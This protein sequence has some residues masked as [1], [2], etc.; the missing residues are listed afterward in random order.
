MM[1][2]T[3]KFEYGS[4]NYEQM[5]V[6]I[7]K[8]KITLTKGKFRLDFPPSFVSDFA[9]EFIFYDISSIQNRVDSLEPNLKINSFYCLAPYYP[10]HEYDE[11]IPIIGAFEYPIVSDILF[12]SKSGPLHKMMSKGLEDRKKDFILQARLQELDI[13]SSFYAT[14]LV[15]NQMSVGDIIIPIPA[16]PKY[17]FNSVDHIADKMGN[18]LKIYV[19]KDLVKRISDTEKKFEIL[20][21]NKLLDGS[22]VILV[23]DIY[24]KGETI[25]EISSILHQK[26]CKEIA[27][28]TL[29]LTDHNIYYHK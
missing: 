1:S 5:D 7:S 16:K 4:L 10:R 22:N 9:K 24:T 17:T 11:I 6:I 29:G 18:L 20:D 12:N 8:T 28:V 3:I 15:N 25:G 21:P 23:D 14:I 2:Q 13:L 19:R 27:L 26:R